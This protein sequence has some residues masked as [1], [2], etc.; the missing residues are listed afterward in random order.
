[1]GNLL[2]AAIPASLAI[3]VSAALFRD[4]AAPLWLALPLA[5]LAS[6]ALVAPVAASLS[7]VFPKTVDLSSI[8]NA[9]N[10]HQAATLLA[11][12]FFIRR[13]LSA[14]A[15]AVVY[16]TLS[17]LL[18][19]SI[20][21]LHWFPDA[22]I[23]GR[24]LTPFKNGSEFVIIAM[25]LT[26]LV[27]LIR[28]RASF[29]R[30]VLLWLSGSIV[31]L[32]MAEA[33]F[34]MYVSVYGGANMVGHLLRVAATFGLYRAIIVTSLVRPYGVLFRDLKEREVA[35]RRSEGKLRTAK[36]LSDALNEIDAAMRSSLDEDTI[37]QRVVGLAADAM[38]A[39]AADIALH[40]RGRWV[41]R[42]VAGTHL[43][44]PGTD[45]SDEQLPLRTRV[46]REGR[47][48]VLQDVRDDAETLAAVRQLGWDVGSYL[49]VPLSLKGDFIGVITFSHVGEAVAFTSD[50]LDFAER[51]AASV[52]LALENARLYEIQHHIADTLQEALLSPPPDVP[53]LRFAHLYRSA[54]QATRV[55]GDFYDVFE[56]SEGIVGIIVGDVSG[57]GLDAAATTALVKTAIK[58]HAHADISPHVVMDRVNAFMHR[59]TAEGAFATVFFAMLDIE[60]GMLSYCSGGHPPALVRHVDGTVRLLEASSPLVGAFD[61]VGYCSEDERLGPGEVLVLYTD[62]VIECRGAVGLYGE[63]RLVE[64][65]A[66][67]ESGAHGLPAAILEDINAFCGGVLADDVAVLAIQAA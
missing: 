66:A 20:M 64:V 22:F 14:T 67:W 35:L 4:G 13:R 44:E 57:K 18:L 33:A 25:M 5:L 17:T 39:D 27:L 15:D 9:S 6:C 45:F 42:Y 60:T 8:G 11:A 2:I 32:A 47:A 3:L 40:E 63:D 50:Q 19:A 59:H 61:D 16:G 46:M 48:A 52:S 62:G 43:A 41:I 23:E 1:V 7:A 55:G 56:V 26:G 51:L 53:G 65:V 54:T 21:R 30:E 29:D 37:M 24:G 34:T 28:R 36:A 10:A 31:L 38:G 49:V 58:A 12:P